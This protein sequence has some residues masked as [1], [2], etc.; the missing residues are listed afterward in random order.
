MSGGGGAGAGAAGVDQTGLDSSDT[1]K[2]RV[3]IVSLDFINVRK[4]VPL[5]RK[6]VQKM[7][8]R[9]LISSFFLSHSPTTAKSFA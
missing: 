4:V 3:Y 8:L 7:I 2:E 6:T 1:V 9:S 5:F